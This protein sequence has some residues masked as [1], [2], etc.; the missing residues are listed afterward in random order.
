MKHPVKVLPL[1]MALAFIASDA[2][3]LG[4]GTLEVKSQL[5]QPLVAE[6]PLIGVGP[7]ELDALSVRLAPPEAFD[8]VGLP[9]PAGV[10]ANLQFSVGRNARGEPVV[11]VTTS[12]RVDDPFVA[13]L[14]E[15]D[16]GRGSVVREFTALVDPPHIAA[17]VVTPM[18][19][20]TVAAVPAPAPV[21]TPEPAAEM[22]PLSVP[23][24]PVAETEP[25]PVAEPLPPEPVAPLP[26]PTPAPVAATPPPAE[27]APQPEAAPQP[28]PPPEPAPQPVVAEAPPP[29]QPRP[30]PVP[31]AIPAATPGSHEVA[32][33]ETLWRIASSNQQGTSVA[34]MMLAI[35]RANPDAFLRDNIN[36][37]R[38][39]A[40]LRIP[41]P[42]EARGLANAEAEDRVREQMAAWRALSPTPAPMPSPGEAPTAALPPAATAQAPARPSATP[43]TPASGRLE[44]APPAGAGAAGAQSGASSGGSGSELRAQLDQAREDLSVREAELR[45]LQSRLTEQESLA[46]EQKR[47]IEL[48]DRQLSAMEQAL[49]EQRTGEAAASSD[50]TQPAASGAVEPA[51]AGAIAS[52]PTD[53]PVVVT[54]DAAPA[55]EAADPASPAPASPTAAAPADAPA[56]AAAPWY[57]NPMVLG[58]GGLVLVGGLVGLLLRRRRSPDAK[59][60]LPNVPPAAGSRSRLSDDEDFLSNLP[61]SSSEESNAAAVEAEAD[62]VPV[63]A[64]APEAPTVD[65]VAAPATNPVLRE[66]ERNIDGAPE[67]LDAHVALLRQ[68]Y[69]TGDT[70]AFLIAAERMRAQVEKPG[71]SRWR[72]VVVMGMGLVPGHALFRELQWNPISGID[73]R[74]RP[75]AVEP[76]PP[77][78]PVVE[79]F[80]ERETAER[81]IVE[82]PTTDE[83]GLDDT[84]L[85]L[86]KAYIEIGDV[87]GARGMLEE[88]LAEGSA[89]ARAEAERLLKSIG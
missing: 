66:L 74:T 73:V 44:I 39:G 80:D 62:A 71:D 31:A 37:L 83:A 54:P 89:A 69:N 26:E 63:A 67:D 82:L 8:R 72:E 57:S 79:A 56:D 9:R 78:P 65:N 51:A 2:H 38:K 88:V 43:S 85:E 59:R 18:A 77:A 22:P 61:A 24:P 86:A 47:L 52:D 3:A 15:A 49:R 6:I 81:P 19:A 17:A 68:L 28:P 16:W 34:Q 76:E 33:G 46:N 14:L 60:P 7:G 12:N 23:S 70:E 64:P 11:R 75:A 30:T 50:G 58:A 84:R 40:V 55:A 5:N 36:L 53:A 20:P 41:T 13:F 48:K 35:Q 87:D 4:L 42:D 21:P 45:E 32:E 25:A 10:T 1:A 29:P 27:P